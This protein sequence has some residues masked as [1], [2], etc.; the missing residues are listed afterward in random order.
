MVLTKPLAFDGKV[1][2]IIEPPGRS[3]S[4]I[5][6]DARLLQEL[7]SLVFAISRRLIFKGLGKNKL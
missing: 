4:S 2:F 5:F 6:C 1:L 7:T 3:N